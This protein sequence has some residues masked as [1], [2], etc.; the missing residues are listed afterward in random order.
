MA[1]EDS[2]GRGDVRRWVHIEQIR[3]RYRQKMPVGKSRRT[4]DILTL[5]FRPPE[6]FIQPV[7]LFQWPELDCCRHEP[8]CEPFSVMNQGG[9]LCSQSGP[10]SGARASTV[11][12]CLVGWIPLGSWPSLP[13]CPQ[14][15]SQWLTYRRHPDYLMYRNACVYAQSDPI[16]CS[17]PGSSVHRISQARILE[18]FAFP[19]PGD[20]PNTGIEPSSPALAGGFFTT[21]PT[22]KPTNTH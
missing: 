17:L 3:V 22:R 10:E 14:H 12:V 5:G 11:Q 8:P 20:L 4:G 16:D 18:W 15:A 7:D 1:F 6:L 21:K 13:L 19:S 9:W 2:R